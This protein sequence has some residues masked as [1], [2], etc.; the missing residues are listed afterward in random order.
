MS[1]IMKELQEVKKASQEQT[2]ASQNLSAVVIGKMDEIDNQVEE[3]EKKFDA[4]IAQSRLENAIFRQSKNQFCNLTDFDLDFFA[5][6]SQYSIEVSLYRT[7]NNGIP[8]AQRDIEEQEIMAAMGLHGYTYFQPAIR[9]M[10]LKWSGYDASQHASH[11]IYP[12]PVGNGTGATTVASYAK[13]ITGSISN[14]WLNGVTGSWSLCGKHTQ[15]HPGRYIHAHPEVSSESGEVLFI[16]P[17]IVSGYIPLDKESP[18]WGY[19]PSMYGENPYD[20]KPG[21]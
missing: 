15:G 16:W 10:K 5:K 1:D 20:A 19:F 7:I 21:A 13:L 3:A 14:W 18:K 2:S 9:V 6:N 4:F 11:S 12:M 8:W 17:A